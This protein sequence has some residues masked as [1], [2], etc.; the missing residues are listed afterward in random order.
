MKKNKFLLKAVLAFAL[1]LCTKEI[2]AQGSGTYRWMVEAGYNAVDFNSSGATGNGRFNE[3][4]NDKHYNIHATSIRF[5]IVYNFK[6]GLSPEVDMSVNSIDRFGSE[7]VRG[8]DI[9]YLSFTG[10]AKY[11]LSHI[12]GK[13][14]FFGKRG[15]FDPYLGLKIGMAGMDN[16]TSFLYDAEAGFNIW[17]LD[18]YG[19]NIQTEYKRTT[20]QDNVM[21]HFEH[22]VGIAF[23]FGA[24][25]T[26]KDGIK[27]KEDKCPRIKGL[28]KNKGCPD[29]DGD[30]VIDRNDPCPLEKGTKG[31]CPD[32]D[33]DG[34]IDKKDKC[35]NLKG[36]RK[37]NGCPD[38]DNDGVLDSEDK[39]P[40]EAGTTENGGCPF[41]D[42]DNDGVQDKDDKCPNEAGVAGEGGCPKVIITLKAL[43]QIQYAAKSIKFNTDNDD[44]APKKSKELD[45]ILA[46]MKEFKNARFLITGNTD[47][48]GSDTYNEKLS[49]RRAE[50]VRQYL[51]ENGI[52]ASR[53]E[54]KGN[55]EANPISTNKT[56]KGRAKNRRVS[57]SVLNM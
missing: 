5:N 11:G 43:E 25:D 33:G 12:F 19:L 3:F 31:G 14:G 13:E 10:G 54:V 20:N 18:Q 21:R 30:G 23:R 26:D 17:F 53:L 57:F 42:S 51:I 48:V 46:L 56:S 32:T 16:Q 22:F 4:F 38:K 15:W 40:E 27:D 41:V 45:E 9:P 35:P 37:T 50:G 8:Q 7:R 55:G 2:S 24:S 36:D 39:C 6:I 28:K 34:V 44:F 47:N 52:E 29:S 1:L 49:L